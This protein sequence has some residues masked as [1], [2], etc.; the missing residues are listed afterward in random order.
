M[1][2]FDLISIL[3]IIGFCL[4]GTIKGFIIEISEIGGL[5]ISFILAM[6][7]PLGLEMGVVKYVVSFLVYFFTISIFF[8]ILSKIIHKT[9]LAFFDRILGAVVGT[10]KGIIVVIILFL[11]I[12]LVPVNETH[13]NLSDSFFY[14]TAINVKNPLKTFLKGRIKGLDHYKEKIPLPQKEE[15]ESEPEDKIIKI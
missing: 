4:W 13:S 6:Y 10:I 2:L 8:S 3:V 12:S 14:K 9:P 1:N 5:I 15:N 11:I 7:L